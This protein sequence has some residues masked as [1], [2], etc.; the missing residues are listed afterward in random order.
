MKIGI[1]TI[2]AAAAAM[3]AGA[4]LA[5]K[6]SWAGEGKGKGKGQAKKEMSGKGAKHFTADHRVFVKEYYADEFRAG[7]CPPGLAK[8][9]NGC[10]PPGL[11]KKWRV[12]QPLP[13]DVVFYDLP[14]AL[15]VKIGVPPPGH[16]YVRVASDILLIAVGTAMVVEAIDDLARL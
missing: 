16:K 14:P 1:L 6:P 7:R 2:L 13:R 11:A 10:M 4:A 9:R 3:A 12:G 5:E 15:V 8:K